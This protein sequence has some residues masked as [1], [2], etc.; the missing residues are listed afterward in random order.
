MNKIVEYFLTKHNTIKNN[1]FVEQS[2][3]SFS[4]AYSSYSDYKSKY[5]K[6]ISE[7]EEQENLA[8]GHGVYKTAHLLPDGKILLKSYCGEY[9]K[10]ETLSK[11]LLLKKYGINIA[12]PLFFT[13]SNTAFKKKGK[14][15]HYE[16]Q[17]EAKG[18]FVSALGE[19]FLEEHLFAC[20]P[21]LKNTRKTSEELFNE[22]NLAMAKHRAKTHLPFLSK[23]VYNFCSLY[24]L[25]NEDMHAQNIYYS[26][27]NGY[28]FFDIDFDFET[29]KS[30][31]T[32]TQKIKDIE[33]H[34]RYYISEPTI[35]TSCFNEL[36]TRGYGVQQFLCGF[37]NS[38]NFSQFVYNGILMHQLRETFKANEPN[39]PVYNPNFPHLKDFAENKLN[40]IFPNNELSVF[41]INS[42]TLMNLEEALKTNNTQALN[43]IREEYSLPSDF[44]FARIDIPNFLETMQKT[45]DFD[46]TNPPQP[47]TTQSAINHTQVKDVNGKLEFELV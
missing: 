33:N 37:V 14:I 20:N 41:A 39:N 4:N 45:H 11:A 35:A 47:Q 32:N 17:E 22:Y 46:F 43:D 18:S 12:L 38:Y 25:Q 9:R 21:E 36:I 27:T 19:S 5:C 16:I 23:F 44:N 2:S 42:S 10:S 13:S 8:C 26:S 28:T 24:G 7:V 1:Q 31:I 15:T 29:K 40:S 3:N 6:L 34:I 30:S